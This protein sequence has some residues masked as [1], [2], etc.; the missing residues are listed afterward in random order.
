MKKLLLCIFT[1]LS[2]LSISQT[3]TGI[4]QLRLGNSVSSVLYFTNTDD[5]IKCYKR[6]E[7]YDNSKNVIELM[8]DTTSDEK[9][10]YTYYTPDVRVLKFPS[11]EINSE[12]TLTEVY[13]VFYMDTLIKI[14]SD[15][16]LK[17]NDALTLKYGEPKTDIVETPKE[18]TL[19]N[20]NNITLTDQM[21]TKKWGT[22]PKISCY[23][24]FSKYYSGS[25]DPKYLSLFSLYYNQ[26]LTYIDNENKK[27][28]IR[29]K[30]RIE[31]EKK[32]KLK[33]F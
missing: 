9:L 24:L 16:N 10:T 25:I 33:D 23:S 6:R 13:L 1:F 28:E 14:S 29:I 15:G 3:I 2:F 21:L 4:G 26:S 17:L 8:S 5:V 18:Y 7:I 32:N 30:E 11:I 31:Q 12:V 22:N 19:R 20:G 27:Y